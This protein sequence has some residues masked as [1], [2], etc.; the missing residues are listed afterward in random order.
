MGE[1]YWTSGVALAI[2]KSPT[3]SEKEKMVVIDKIID[4]QFIGNFPTDEDKKRFIKQ[5]K[6]IR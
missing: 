2:L 6:E 5:I 3:I 4:N 1:R